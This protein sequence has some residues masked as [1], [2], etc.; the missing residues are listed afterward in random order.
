MPHVHS[1]TVEYSI[2]LPN[3]LK[4]NAT[5][6]IMVETVQTH[7]TF[8]WPDQASQADPQSLKYTTDLFVL[9]P[10][11]TL[12]QRTKIRYVTRFHYFC[13]MIEQ[14]IVIQ[15]TLADDPFVHRTR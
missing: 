8:P 3:S 2:E 5:T 1:G 7:A 15:V 10:Y 4:Y 14:I 11:R 6:N 13:G 9:S 12:V